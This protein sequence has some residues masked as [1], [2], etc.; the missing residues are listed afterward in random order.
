MIL[1]VILG[2][3][4]TLFLMC[5]GLCSSCAFYRA[6]AGNV[7]ELGVKYVLAWDELCQESVGI[8]EENLRKL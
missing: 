3:F 4:S 8:C 2:V 5:L 1:G 7:Y 6:D